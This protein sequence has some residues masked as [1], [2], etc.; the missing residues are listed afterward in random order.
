[1]ICRCVC[2]FYLL[3]AQWCFT[4]LKW[5]K[6]EIENLGLRIKNLNRYFLIWLRKYLSQKDF[7]DFDIINLELSRSHLILK[8]CVIVTWNH[9]F[10]QTA[11]PTLQSKLRNQMFLGVKNFFLIF[12]LNIVLTCNSISKN[13]NAFVNNFLWVYFRNYCMDFL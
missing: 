6:V 12:S 7:S 3:L 11:F 10:V 2:S 1:M 8:N 13:T 5:A 9:M 4:K